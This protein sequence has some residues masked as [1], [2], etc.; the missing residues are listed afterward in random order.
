MQMYV[1]VGE[2]GDLRQADARE[3]QRGSAGG[4]TGV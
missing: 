3:G 4:V 2:N 1:G